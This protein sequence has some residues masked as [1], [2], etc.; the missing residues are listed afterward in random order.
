MRGKAPHRRRYHP[1]CQ[2][3]L[4][5][6]TAPLSHVLLSMSA[7]HSTACTPANQLKPLR[8]RASTVRVTTRPSARNHTSCTANLGLPNLA[9]AQRKRKRLGI[10]TRGASTLEQ[11][12]LL[13]LAFLDVVRILERFAPAHLHLFQI[14]APCIKQCK[15]IGASS[16]ASCQGRRDGAMHAEGRR[17]SL[18]L[19]RTWARNSGHKEVRRTMYSRDNS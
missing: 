17:H 13:H 4:G 16:S 15:A 6:V 1:S 10:S 5:T 9:R 12:P 19:T 2:T 3:C 18:R 14:D 7:G 8:A 11:A